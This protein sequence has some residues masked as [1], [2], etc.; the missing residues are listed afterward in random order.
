[1]IEDNVKIK[2]IGNINGRNVQRKNDVNNVDKSSLRAPWLI[3]DNLGVSCD[4]HTYGQI[5][6][7][8]KMSFTFNWKDTWRHDVN[9]ARALNFETNITK[10]H[11]LVNDY[12]YFINFEFLFVLF[13]THGVHMILFNILT[14]ILNQYLHICYVKMH[15][16]LIL[17]VC[18]I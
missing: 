13:F 11:S 18:E 7:S 3:I 6:L 17:S 5:T 16:V 9:V 4:F 12:M 15:L 8:E 2:R 1:M 10:W 14:N